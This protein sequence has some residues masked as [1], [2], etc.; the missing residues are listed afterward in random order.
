MRGSENR[1]MRRFTCTESGKREQP[2][3]VQSVPDQIEEF[4]SKGGEIKQ[5]PIGYS[6]VNNGLSRQQVHELRKRASLEAGS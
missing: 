3:W 6:G 4:L 5:I 1:S 2:E